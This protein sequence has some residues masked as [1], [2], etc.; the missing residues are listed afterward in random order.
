MDENWDILLSMLPVGWQE[1]AIETKALKGL[2]KNKS[3]ENLLRTLLI[4]LS[5]GYSLRETAVRAREANLAEMTDVALLKRLRKCKDWLAALCQMLFEERGIDLKKQQSGFDVRLVDATVVKEPGRTG[6]LWRVHYSLRVPSLQCDYFKV[7]SNSGVKTGEAFSQFPLH[8]GDHVMGDRAYGRAIGIEYANKHQAAILVRITPNLI[9]VLDASGNPFSWID[10]LAEIPQTGTI[11]SWDVLIPVA[12][13][14]RIP[15][16]I[17]AIRKTEQAILAANIRLKERARR[18]KQVLKE[19]TVLYANYVIVFTTFD[20]SLFT[21]ADILQWYRLRWQIELVFKRFKQLAQFGH[22][23]K[24]TDDSSQ[25]WLYGKLFVALMTEKLI[26]QARV[27]S[28]WG[29]DI[30]NPKFKT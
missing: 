17:C 22:L 4:H 28:P 27:I 12:D 15:G 7:T 25:A 1:K 14:S 19:R 6:S 24:Y 3:A 20:K 23:P 11:G 30:I 21:P 9:H 16:R 26:W 2:R 10:R 29:Y 13:G 8:P 18:K 5:Y